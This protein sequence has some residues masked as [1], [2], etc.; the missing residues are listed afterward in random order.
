MKMIVGTDPVLIDTSDAYPDRGASGQTVLIQNLGPGTVYADFA[1]NPL[2][3][4]R[5]AAS[6]DAWEFQRAAGQELYVVASEA[7]TD[8]RVVAVG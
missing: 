5:L 1:E 6:G 7:D 3:G 4:I 2:D 8:V